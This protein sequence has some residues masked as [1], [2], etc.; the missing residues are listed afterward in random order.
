MRGDTGKLHSAPMMKQN[1][2][3]S[4]Y[5][6]PVPRY[7]SYPT[8]PHFHNGVRAD[9]Y[10]E[11]LRAIPE[12]QPLS[13]YF[14]IPYCDTLCW[15]CGCH[16]KITKRYGPIKEYLASLLREIDLVANALG[17]RRPVRHIHLGGGS[18]TILK[19]D[20][21][22]RLGERINQNFCLMD[23]AEFAVEID[24]RGVD[25]VLIRAMADAGVNRAS[26][27]VQDV[28]P[29]V[30]KA[31]NR[32]QPFSETARVIEGLRAEGITGINVDLIYGLP[33]QTIRLVEGTIE[34]VAKLRPSRLA[35][36]GYA[37]VP[38]MKTHQKMI[39]EKVLPNAEERLEQA[40]AAAKAIEKAGYVPIGLDHFALPE[41]PLAVAY[42]KGNLRRNFQGYTTDQSEI[43]IGF[44]ASAIGVNP[45]GY[46]QNE[47][48]LRD[49]QRRVD[50]GILPVTKGVA[51]S[52]DD[53]LRREVIQDIMCSYK[54][55]LADTMIRHNVPNTYFDFELEGLA[56]MEAD[57][58]IE[59]DGPKITVT[60]AGQPFV[61]TIAARFD[62]YLDNGKG[63]HSMAV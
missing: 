17:P 27:G 24:P 6:K 62:A 36:F 56:D 26:V 10:M 55:D 61:R 32:I 12:D 8:A 45:G 44:G 23:D 39:D 31:I 35:L 13:L 34:A 4:R 58:L 49:Y 33:H 43:L 41:D 19:P 53:A 15:F 40:E 54:V 29:I 59:R 50:G 52:A 37:H 21:F 46:V 2:L 5:G 18:P 20:D 7:T 51:V 38:W 22:L 48:S 57:G 28:N 3:L 63:R 60:K 16:T 11:W 9:T 1:D 42:A 30:Q 14:H 47:P 25:D